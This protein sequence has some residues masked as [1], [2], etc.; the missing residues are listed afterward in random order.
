M[1]ARALLATALVTLLPV[2]AHAELDCVVPTREEGFDAS[3][4]GAETLRRAARA[5]AAIVQKNAVF[6]AGQRPIRVRTTIGYH[7]L[8]RYAASVITTAYNQ[9]AWLEGGCK[10]SKFADRGGG[11]A[12]GRIVIFL[13]DPESLLGGTLG[14]AE[15]VASFAPAPA[16]TFAG[17][18]VFLGS[19]DVRDPRVLLSRGG[20]R[21]WV[22]VTVAEMLAWR[23][24]ELAA[25]E[26]EYREVQRHAASGGLDEAKIEEIYAGMKRV[27]PAGAEKTRARMLASLPKMRAD[28]ARQSAAAAEATAKRRAAFDAY[29]ASLTPAQLASQGTISGST[30]RAGASRVDDPSGRPLARVDPGYAQRDPRKLHLVVVSVAPQPTTDPDH[31]WQQAS[32]EAL[33][34]GALAALLDP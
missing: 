15:L 28:A 22:P 17:H 27:D 30:T 29:R 26:A 33:D 3:R 11:L 18:P 6:M 13:N 14:D 19:G 10:V 7:G 5:V 20:Y 4:P 9:K 31:A 8:D 1:N 25:R 34:F 21:P 24:R 16:G 32:Y 23:E 2:A 12:D